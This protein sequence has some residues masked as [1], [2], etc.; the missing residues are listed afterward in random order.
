MPIRKVKEFDRGSA[1]STG[2]V[3]GSSRVTH[4]L[5]DRKHFYQLKPSIKDNHLDRKL[6]VRF[7]D[8]FGVTDRENI[9]EVIA[10]A[11]G[12]AIIPDADNGD[13]PLVPEVDLV[14]D[15]E[16]ARVLVASRYL[17]THSTEK[18]FNKPL[19]LDE[20]AETLGA[21]FKKKKHARI[22]FDPDDEVHQKVAV[23]TEQSARQD[24]ANAIA[25][26]ILVGDHDINPGNMVVVKDKEGNVRVARIDFGHGFGDL[27]RK[28]KSTST[29]SVI[30]YINREGLAGIGGAR[31]PKLWRDYMGI[32]PS[33]EMAKAFE[34]LSRP[35]KLKAAQEA[36]NQQEKHFQELLDVSSTQ[37]EKDHVIRTL[38]SIAKNQGLDISKTD[39]KSPEKA[40]RNIFGQMRES[41]DQNM[42]DMKAAAELMKLQADINA[43]IKASG[44]K[45]DANHLNTFKERFKALPKG[46]KG[47]WFKSDR[48]HPAFKGGLTEYIAHTIKSNRRPLPVADELKGKDINDT[49]RNIIQKLNEKG[50]KVKV[51]GLKSVAMRFLGASPPKS[52]S[53]VDKNGKEV[54]TI[55]IGAGNI[56]IET[57]QNHT[58]GGITA[59]PKVASPKAPPTVVDS[60]IDH[61]VVHVAK[62]GHEVISSPPIEETPSLGLISI[63]ELEVTELT[64]NREITHHQELKR[65]PQGKLSSSAPAIGIRASVVASRPSCTSPAM[66]DRNRPPRQP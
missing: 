64:V 48:K 54:G 38:A 21:K 13:T 20:Y 59:S 26:S 42:Q 10:A 58:L 39:L 43:H 24:L 17:V 56:T 34:D 27:T 46:L 16:N 25:L 12:R 50:L 36:I 8:S 44:G 65:E 49:F 32:I 51:R 63:G 35:E 57:D 31:K 55:K 28:K 47:T 15:E 60:P 14:Y 61:P 37:A 29:N 19:T 40:M 9:G 11:I 23:I 52:A 66:Q 4:G 3:T 22:S 5:G 45:L 41:I 53:I 62:H 33:A 2:G 30:D 6:K 18:P 7:T 1:T